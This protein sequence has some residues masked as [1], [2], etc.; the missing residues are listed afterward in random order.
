MVGEVN[1]GY[2]PTEHW[3]QKTK[4]YDESNQTRPLLVVSRSSI[5]SP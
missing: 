2:E 1:S 3:P 4:Q 5:E